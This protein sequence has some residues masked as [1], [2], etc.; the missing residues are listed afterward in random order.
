MRETLGRDSGSPVAGLARGSAGPC[1][2][3]SETFIVD[4]KA[5]P[6]SLCLPVDEVHVW[7]ANLDLEVSLVLKLWDTLS[8]LE[9]ERV[10]RFHLERD[11]NR[12]IVGKGVLGA[13]LGRYLR[14]DPKIASVTT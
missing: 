6:K 9:R 1:P 13:I 3:L 7:R 10:Y 4:W 5:A 11:R 2:D 8:G 12:F 14:V